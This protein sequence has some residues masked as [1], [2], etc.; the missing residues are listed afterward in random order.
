MVYEAEELLKR[1]V[2]EYFGCQ[3][4][5]QYGVND[6]ITARYGEKITPNVLV[7]AFDCVNYRM[8]RVIRQFQVVQEDEYLEAEIEELFLLSLEDEGK[9]GMEYKFY[10]QE[11]LFPDE[12]TEKMKW[13]RNRI[14]N[15][16]R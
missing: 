8:D 2:E 5:N 15:N 11:E 6:W 7:R 12:G 1:T 13:F 14:L 3:T 10:Y 4:A 9:R 16:S